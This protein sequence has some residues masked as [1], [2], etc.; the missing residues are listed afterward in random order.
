VT[1]ADNGSGSQD[2]FF[3]DGTALETNAGVKYPISFV[4]NNRYRFDLSAAI[5]ADAP[6][7]FSTTPDTVVTIGNV[8]PSTVTDY[9]TGVT[10]SGNA[11]TAG[12]YVDIV[13]TEDTPTPLYLWGIQQN[14]GLDTSL[15]GAAR[16]ISVEQTQYFAGSDTFT[17]NGNISL[18][19]TTTIINSS[20]DLVGNL[21]AGSSGQI[22]ILAYG[23]TSVGNTLI[24]VANAAWGGGST[25]NL[26]AVGS[27]ATF[28][29]VAN[30][31]F[32]TGNNGVTFA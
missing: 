32:C 18:E 15:L 29:Y 9:S 24:T 5:N 28:Q 2:V 20:D 30:K 21:A 14:P 6:L 19:T 7:R 4:E 13:I 27:A 16:P 17:A 10:I 22:K 8:P 11:G 23:N 1:I 31:W 12:S 3:L 26:S 25:A